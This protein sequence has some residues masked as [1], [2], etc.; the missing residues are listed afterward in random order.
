MITIFLDTEFTGLTQDAKLIS[1]AM[2][3]SDENYFYAEL[4]NWNDNHIGQWVRENVIPH[5]EF[6]N[7]HYVVAGS[8]T[9]IRMKG[10]PVSVKLAL[11]RW[12]AQFDA[13]EVWADILGY[14][15]VLFCNIFGGSLQIPKN[16][17]YIPYDLSTLFKA[18]S[19]NPDLNRFDFV[20]ELLNK[21][22][23]QHRHH[24]LTDARVG[25]LCLNKINSSHG[26]LLFL[27][28]FPVSF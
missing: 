11:E 9:M 1:V 8:E 20:S 22:D 13:I 21:H 10:D 27:P 25:M 3:H 2:Y 17:F 24:A 19:L 7:Q 23:R 4:N 28:H 26:R 16:I 15:W 12:L 18:Y 6:S 14:D 5:L